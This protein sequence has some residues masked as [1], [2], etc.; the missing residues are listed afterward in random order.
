MLQ[1]DSTPVVI[2]FVNTGMLD[3]MPVGKHIPRAGRKQGW[4]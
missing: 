4:S 2:P 1:T 3:T